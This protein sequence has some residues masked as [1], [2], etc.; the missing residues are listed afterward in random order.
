MEENPTKFTDENEAK[1]EAFGRLTAMQAYQAIRTAGTKNAI[2]R[3][4]IYGQDGEL[5]FEANLPH[6]PTTQDERN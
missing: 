5:V 1:I 4:E 2:D 3:I 6:L